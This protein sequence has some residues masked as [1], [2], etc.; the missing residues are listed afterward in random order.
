MNHAK[1]IL[2]TG[3]SGFIGLNLSEYMLSQGYQ[4]LSIDIKVP[5]NT[6]LLPYWKECSILNFEKLKEIILEFSPEY[7]IHLAARTDLDGKS[8]EDYNVNTTGT[9]NII[10]IANQM[11]S[12]KRVV[13]TSSMYV[14]EPGKIPKDFVTYTPHTIY[15]ESKVQGELLV[16]KECKSNYEWVI[17]RP[18]SIWGPYFGI[19]YI[20]FFKIVY[21][22]RYFDFGNTCTKTYGYIENTIFQIQKIME[23]EDTNNK[24]YY[25]GDYNPIQISEWANEISIE[26]F[27]G[28]IKKMPFWLIKFAGFIGDFLLKGKIKFPITS[29]RLK[30]MTTNNV[31]PLA[32]TF[33]ITGE[34]PISR[35]EGTIKTINW[36]RDFKGYI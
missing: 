15:G 8:S 1:K 7:I 29:F 26:M 34:L 35:R 4:I 24:T 27:K 12:L 13:F 23:S 30:N 10:S 2:I 32:N 31:L 16:K 18:T 14:C 36:L 5:E 17:I 19:P 20:D 9:K 22:G 11:D 33:N 3:G 6:K 25:L 28:K 21:Q